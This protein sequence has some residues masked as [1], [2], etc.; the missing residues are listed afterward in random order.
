M[1]IDNE[2]TD[3]RE[4]SSANE[5]SEKDDECWKFGSDPNRVEWV[6]GTLD[7]GQ[8]AKDEKCKMCNRQ[9]TSITF[10]TKAGKRNESQ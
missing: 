5:S 7:Q 10:V 2:E 4:S 3:G 6:A 9:G 8:H 1:E